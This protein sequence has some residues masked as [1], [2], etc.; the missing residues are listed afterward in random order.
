MKKIKRKFISLGSIGLLVL[1]LTACNSKNT[2]E[3]TYNVEKVNEIVVKT[4][5]QDIEVRP[6]DDKNV[7]VS[8]KGAKEIPAQING[9]V[10]TI[11]IEESSGF[12]NLKTKTLYVDV[13]EKIYKKVS[14]ITTSGNVSGEKIKAEE[15]IF[16]SDSGDIDINGYEGKKITGKVV[17]G[18][19][20]LEKVDGDLAVKNA[21]GNIS[22][23]HNGTLE[24]DSDITSHSG[25]IDI[26]FLKKPNDLKMDASTESGKIKTSLFPSDDIVS[27]GAGYKLSSQLGS[28][29]P[30]LIIHSSSGNISLN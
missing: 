28:K 2:K 4:D 14:I 7:K 20:K 3:E 8:M 22:I 16:T 18:H 1:G 6:T 11:N 10:L 13:P 19:I 27:K 23:T 5:G 15:L 26:Q 9:D 30:A 12:I 29:G 17:S 21:D 25:K 24:H